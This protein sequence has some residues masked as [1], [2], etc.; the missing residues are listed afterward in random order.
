MSKKIYVP[1]GGVAHKTTKI[2]APVNG[3]A[4]NVKKVY[5][6]VDGIARQCF[7][8]SKVLDE[9]TWEEIGKIAAAGDAS[10]Y[11]AIGDIK[12]V[13]IKGKVG[14]LS[15]NTTLY[16]YI[17]GF[18]HNGAQN[19][20]D[21]GLFQYVEGKNIALVDGNYGYNST[22]GEK[23]FSINHETNLN[24]GGWKDCDLRYDVLGSTDVDHGNASATCATKPVANTLM[25]ALPAELRAVMKP[26][27][28]YTDNT[29]GGA[30]NAS[31]VTATTDFLP[32]LAEF[33][34]FGS[35]THANSAEQNY[36]KQY[37]FFKNEN[38]RIKYRS[39]TKDVAAS[40][41]LR[42]PAEFSTSVCNVNALGHPQNVLTHFSSG[43]A[44]IF[45]V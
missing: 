24:Y 34:V 42:S 6:G 19:T 33:E 25:A 40:W 10:D 8:I 23:Y 43:L 29:G 13:A 3:V 15:V 21:F 22:S 28:I 7:V 36:Q 26:M 18:D 14:A 17:I 37:D 1:V 32:L 9:C 30:N 2:Y 38:S 31:Y 12:T 44:P 41:W 45:R 11:F 39:D 4:H 27:T 16:A 35:R 20:I 5:K